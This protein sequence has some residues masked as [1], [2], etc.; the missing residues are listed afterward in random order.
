[1]I[2][3]CRRSAA[4]RAGVRPAAGVNGW[5][6]SAPF[7]KF[8]VH[9]HTRHE[10]RKQ[11]APVTYDLESCF[12]LKFLPEFAADGVGTSR[13]HRSAGRAAQCAIST[14][15]PHW[16]GCGWSCRR[17]SSAGAVVWVKAP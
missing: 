16:P 17:R 13:V 12:R 4:D 6:A 8:V 1:V 10:L 3:R 11:R 5:R 2:D 9:Q 15:G 14:G 7:P